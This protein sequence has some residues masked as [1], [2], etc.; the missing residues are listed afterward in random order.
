MGSPSQKFPGISKKG[1]APVFLCSGQWRCDDR[2]MAQRYLHFLFVPSNP[3][4]VL[5]PIESNLPQVAFHYCP[6]CQNDEVCN[7]STCA[8]KYGFGVAP[9]LRSRE[10]RHLIV[11]PAS[12]GT[13]VAL[14]YS[15]K[16]LN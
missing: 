7:G 5:R 8:P 12:G 14:D 16:T 6:A 2:Q 11:Y 9:T 13:V 4:Q 15:L 3:S 1:R 10:S